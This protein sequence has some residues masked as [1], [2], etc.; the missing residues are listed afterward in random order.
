M[1]S[2]S[3]LP[4]LKAESRRCDVIFIQ[5]LVC[6]ISLAQMASTLLD[7]LEDL[8]VPPSSSVHCTACTCA[9]LCLVSQHCSAPAR[10]PPTSREGCRPLH[11]THCTALHCTALHHL[12]RLV[13]REL[14]QCGLRVGQAEDEGG[15]GGGRVSVQELRVAVTQGDTVLAHRPE[16]CNALHCTWNPALEHALHCT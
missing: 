7:G 5:I 12:Q 10:P 11:S 14:L 15:A 8:V 16:Q 13:R 3:Y 6:N 4:G 9:P 1:N 2:P